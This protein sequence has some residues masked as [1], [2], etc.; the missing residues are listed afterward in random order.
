MIIGGSQELTVCQ[1][2]SWDDDPCIDQTDSECDKVP[3]V[4][5]GEEDPSAQE[6]EIQVPGTKENLPDFQIELQNE[7]DCSQFESIFESGNRNSDFEGF[8]DSE[9]NCTNSEE[10]MNSE[11][12]NSGE[13]LKNT[14]RIK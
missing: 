3:V 10:A 14:R 11:I 13:A 4:F 12:E 5:Q 1:V 6:L 9:I 2:D 7:R 8:S